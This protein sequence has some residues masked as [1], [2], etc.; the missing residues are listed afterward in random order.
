MDEVQQILEHPRTVM[1]FS[2]AGAHV[3]QIIN[4]SLQTYLLS[5]WVREREVFTIEQAV[6]MITS[7]RRPCGGSPIA[8]WCAWDSPPTST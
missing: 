3:S 5:D 1:T 6:R 2:D 8:A 4:A 7:C